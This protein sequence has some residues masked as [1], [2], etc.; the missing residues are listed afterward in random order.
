MNE[1]LKLVREFHDVFSV[2]QAEHGADA[3]ISDMNIIMCQALLMDGGSETLKAMKAGEMAAILS[4]LV[5]LA[6]SALGALA[7]RGADVIDRPVS[8]RHDG[9]VISIMRLLSEKI[10]ACASGGA[11]SYSD[12]YCL[13]KVLAKSFLNADFDK[14]FRMVHDSH[15][16]KVDETGKLNY[17]YAGQI[18]KSTLFKGPDLSDCLYE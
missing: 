15:L 8:W 10:N 5:D 7:F 12:V 3:K 18:R 6:Y 2:S 17:D 16:A 13:C 1:H 9:Y 14:A 11:E 4:G